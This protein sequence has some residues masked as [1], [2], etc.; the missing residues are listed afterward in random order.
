MKLLTLGVLLSIA[1]TLSLCLPVDKLLKK[2]I[3]KGIDFSDVD[4][5][6][7]DKLKKV[8]FN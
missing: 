6:I 4:D 2:Q 7:S 8:R 5:V 1:V 3:F